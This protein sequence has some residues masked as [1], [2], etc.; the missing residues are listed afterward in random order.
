MED[1]SKKDTLT[2]YEQLKPNK[3]PLAKVAVQAAIRSMR[4]V[5]ASPSY[6]CCLV[7]DSWFPWFSFQVDLLPE[8]KKMVL[9]L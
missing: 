5:L 6:L 4:W 2:T 1:G 7:S 8:S 3:I 9:L